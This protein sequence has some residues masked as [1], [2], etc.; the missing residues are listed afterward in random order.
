VYFENDCLMPSELLPTHNERMRNNYLRQ[1]QAYWE[2]NAEQ[3]QDFLKIIRRIVPFKT[4]CLF[5]QLIQQ[6]ALVKIAGEK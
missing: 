5:D 1:A 6:E 2:S 4:K 3:Y